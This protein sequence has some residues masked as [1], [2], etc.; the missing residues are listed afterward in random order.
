MACG[1]TA[2]L[3]LPGAPTVTTA[4]GENEQR[5]RENEHHSAFFS[6]E[7]GAMNFADAYLQVVGCKHRRG[8]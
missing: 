7:T 8:I 6:T 4:V 3:P 5:L 2:V 1:R